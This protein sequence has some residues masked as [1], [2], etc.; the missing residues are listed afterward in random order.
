MSVSL[1]YFAGLMLSLPLLPILLIQAKR[2]KQAVPRLPEA[3]QNVRGSVGTGQRTIRLVTLGESTVAGVGVS[4]H[5]DGITG[6]IAQTISRLTGSKVTWEVIGKS[7]YTAR[8]AAERL[9]TK[10][11]DATVDSIVIGL[12]ANDSFAFNSPTTWQRDI[13]QLITSIRCK[14]ED[15]PIVF[16]NMPPVG[17][18][19]AFPWIMRVILGSLTTLYGL[20]LG[21]LVRKHAK[22]YYVDRPIKFKD[23]AERAGSEVSIDDLFSDGVH[24]SAQTYALW[25]EEVGEF[26]GKKKIV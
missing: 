23:W 26:M 12:G 7:G 14:Y 13:E 2:V 24:P 21:Q 8:K 19:P 5:T 16:A 6:H 22:L 25:G 10:L 4:D 9:V 11:P 17:Q 15:C 20:V 1:M 3:H 18:F